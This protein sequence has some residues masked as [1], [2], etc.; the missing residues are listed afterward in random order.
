MEHLQVSEAQ[1]VVIESVVVFDAEQVNLEQALG[2]VLA[3]EIFAN[4]DQPPYD[5][6][7]MDGYALRS[8]DLTSLPAT[9]DIVEDI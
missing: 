4:R 9:L 2:R 3:E 6:S 7:A 8:A 5:I 1:R